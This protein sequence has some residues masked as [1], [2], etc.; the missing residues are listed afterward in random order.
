M[1]GT[2]IAEQLAL[3]L[4]RGCEILP[5]DKTS[6]CLSV[7]CCVV[8]LQICSYNVESLTDFLDQVSVLC[9][10]VQVVPPCDDIFQL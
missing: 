8:E 9:S 7:N 3:P 5:K 2:L 4:G 10:C 6:F 1:L